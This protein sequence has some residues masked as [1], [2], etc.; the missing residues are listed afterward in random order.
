MIFSAQRALSIF[1]PSLQFH[2]VPRGFSCMREK[3]ALLHGWVLRFHSFPPTSFGLDADEVIRCISAG[4]FD[5]LTQ[6]T[7]HTAFF[8]W[9]R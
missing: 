2:L 9:R 1:S 8:S 6:S 7:Y 5:G 3:A 4:C